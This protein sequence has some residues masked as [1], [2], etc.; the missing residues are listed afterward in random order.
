MRQIVFLLVPLGI[1]A[2][3]GM[4]Y[5]T[6]LWHTVTGLPDS[7]HPSL[8]LF[9]SFALRVCLLLTGLVLATN[10]RGEAMLAAL[11]GVLLARELLVRLLLRRR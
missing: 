5:F 3:L 8:S 10:G 1:G 6:G 9:G 4:V 11:L 2:A 7:R